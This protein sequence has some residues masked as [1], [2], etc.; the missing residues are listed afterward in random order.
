MLLRASLCATALSLAGLTLLAWRCPAQ[1]PDKTTPGE[2]D[3]KL[4]RTYAEKRTSAATVNFNKSLKLPWSSL[5]TIGSRLD[6]AQQSADPV[7]MAHM[8]N[9]LAVA[10]NVSGKKASVTS[11]SVLKESAKLAKLRGDPSE[12]KAVHQVAKQIHG[13][14]NLLSQLQKDIEQAEAAA[15]KQDKAALQPPPLNPVAYPVLIENY[16]EEPISIFM[17]GR[18]QLTVQPLQKRFL[19]FMQQPAPV[20]LYA[21]S[22]DYKW[23]PRNIYETLSS[24]T[25][26]LLPPKT[27][28]SCD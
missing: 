3:Q 12:L 28:D 11:T 24:Y 23:G 25:W 10:E 22:V 19:N 15:A 7:A 27:A 14:K 4:V 13:E 16:T 9:E 17:N 20:T 26:V 1:G 8:A 6:S 18:Y 21:Y 2:L 5:Q